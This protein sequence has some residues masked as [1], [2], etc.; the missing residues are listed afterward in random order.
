MPTSPLRPGRLQWR[1]FRGSDAV[2]GGLLT[3]NQLRSAAWVRLRSDVYADARLTHDHELACRAASLR[4]P[5]TAAIAGPSAASLWGVRHARR[6]RDEIHVVVPPGERI[7]PRLGV[8]IHKVELRPGDV[9]RFGGISRTSPARTAWDVASWL[10]LEAAVPVVDGLLVA[11]RVTIGDLRQETVR[12]HGDRYWRRAA[13]AFQLADPAARSPAESHLRV[14]L[15]QARLTRPVT[16]HPVRLADG[17]VLEPGLAWPAAKLA[18]AVGAGPDP[19][20]ASAG[21]RVLTVPAE[22]LR[23]DMAGVLRQIRETLRACAYPGL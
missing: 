20:L 15:H 13:K 23:E 1:I 17:T 10:D 8:R 7:G 14:R 22:R 9:V 6:P 11:D 3:A 2:R 4:L 16:R 5:S 18:V 12:R 19:R 21:W